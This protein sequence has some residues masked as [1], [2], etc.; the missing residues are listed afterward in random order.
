MSLYHRYRPTTFDEVTGNEDLIA[1]LKGTLLQEDPPH[2]ILFSGPTGCGKTTLSRIVASELGCKG[3]DFQELDS[4]SYRGI[5]DIR[6]IRKQSMYMPVEGKCR[7][8]LLDECH[9]LSNDAMNAL[10]KA[11]EDTPPHVF[12]ILATT[13]PQKLLPTI[14]GRCAKF[15]VSLLNENQLYR[16]LRKV[17]RSE[18]VSIEK[19]ILEQIA[20]DSEGHPRNALQILEQVMSVDPEKR[21]AVAKKT[22]EKQS[23]TIELCRALIGG[24]PWKKVAGI[25]SGL[26]DEDPESIRRAILGYCNSI[27]LKGED[28]QAGKVMEQ[29]LEPLYNT[30]W[31]GLTF[32]C[33]AIVCGEA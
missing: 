14:R 8:W 3:S 24:A 23:Q 2:A 29:M 20:Q 30:G 4:A 28:A 21:L 25:L 18:E 22:A 31:P 17:C 11:L 1:S 9:K 26:K 5:D 6:E 12:Y 33:Y 15:N 13:D 27:L 16:L 10:L 32:A 19:E 7:V